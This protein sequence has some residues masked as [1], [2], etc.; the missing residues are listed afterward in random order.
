MNRGAALVRSAPI[1][2]ITLR[3]WLAE[4]PFTLAMSSGFF[5]FFAHCGALTVLEDE[6]LLPSAL[7]GSSAGALVAGMW[8]AGM[9][10]AAQRDELLRLQRE[11][12]WD[13]ALG[14]GLLRGRLFREKLEGLLPARTFAECRAPLALSVFD[15]RTR[16]TV[17]LD[18]GALAPAIHASCALPVLFQPVRHEGRVLLDGGIL[19][20]PGLV[21]VSSSARVL[22]HHLSSRSP[23]RS[24]QDPALVPPKREG[25]V[26]LVID[27]VPRT[28]PF[29]LHEGRR[30]F[31]AARSGAKRA[32]DQRVTD[33]VARVVL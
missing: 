14:A 33:G 32:L 16:R 13:P 6:G 11:D 7:A 5:G 8:A 31:E 9:S 18:Q 22:H 15:V 29:R 26:A 1:V 2:S 24:T 23:W 25:L 20:R 28:G 27:G 10:A 17:V 19:D 3:E 4:S 12:F 21:G 30:A